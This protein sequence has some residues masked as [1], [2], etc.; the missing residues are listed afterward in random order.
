M[1]Y[2][3]KRAR[4]SGLYTSLQILTLDNMVKSTSVAIALSFRQNILPELVTTC[5]SI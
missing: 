5:L 1:A 3:S 2:S 4:A